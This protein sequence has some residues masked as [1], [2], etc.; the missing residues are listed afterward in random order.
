VGL[1]RAGEGFADWL[2]GTPV[3]SSVASER[4]DA[5]PQG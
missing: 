2:P 3:A 4:R 5:W 1:E